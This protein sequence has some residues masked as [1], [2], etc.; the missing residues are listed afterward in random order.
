MVHNMYGEIIQ[1]W[2]GNFTASR[3]LVVV[4]HSVDQPFNFAA[5]NNI[6]LHLKCNLSNKYDGV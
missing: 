2:V 4:S 1:S 3:I 5:S 6:D